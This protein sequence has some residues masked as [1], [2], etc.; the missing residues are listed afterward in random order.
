MEKTLSSD[1]N[2]NISSLIWK[3]A[4]G[5]AIAWEISKFL[6]SEHPYLAPLSVI[7][8]LQ[9][10]F[11]KT[12]RLSIRRMMGTILGIIVTVL[13]A[14]HL[15][16]NG[17]SLG[18][19]ILIGC[20]VAKWLKLDRIV[21]HQVAI[22]ILFVFV[23]EKQSHLYAIDRLRDTFVGVIVI[24]LIQFIWFRFIAKENHLKPKRSS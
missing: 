3:M 6:G 7:L 23:F 19:L 5:S 22:T 18:M 9:S 12:L 1:A 16:I 13:I 21:I 4:L 15:K 10:S 24:G 20:Y 17:I 14:G 2:K 8:C 11:N